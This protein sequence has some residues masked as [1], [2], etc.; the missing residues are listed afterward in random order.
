MK[1][2]EPGFERTINWNK[3]QFKVT[4]QTRNRYLEFLTNPT[5]REVNRLFVLS[6]ENRSVGESYKQY[7]LT[8]IGIK[9]YN[10]MIDREDFFYQPV[11]NGLRTYDN[12]QK[13]AIGDD[14]T[15]GCLLDYPYFKKYYNLYKLIPIDLSK[16]QKTSC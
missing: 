1:Q 3:Y 10:F 11:E 2:L 4:Q 9:D 16:K 7:F 5:F 13:I 8:T 6:F 12:I 14:Y 15:T